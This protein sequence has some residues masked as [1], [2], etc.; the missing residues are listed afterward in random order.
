MQFLV[1]FLLASQFDPEDFITYVQNAKIAAHQARNGD[2]EGHIV[3]STIHRLK[4]TERPV[5]YG[6][7]LCEGKTQKGLPVGLLPHTYSLRKPQSQGVLPAGGMSRMEDERDIC[8][9][10][11][12]RAQ[13]ECHLSGCE[14]YRNA[15][16]YPSRF[17]REMGLI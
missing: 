11:V 9:V 6:V 5:V 17:V 14:K 3:I 7:G 1:Q 10:L 13:K 12:S 15:M 16:M 4:G 2:W 8:Y